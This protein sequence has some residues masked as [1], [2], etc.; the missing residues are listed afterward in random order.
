M[1]KTLERLVWM[2][3]VFF[4]FAYHRFDYFAFVS[5][6][7]LSPWTRATPNS[8]KKFEFHIAET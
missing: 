5:L 2:E 8:L 1:G 3:G 7:A 6:S 4:S